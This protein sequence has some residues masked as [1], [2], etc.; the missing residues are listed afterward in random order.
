M[1]VNKYLAT[2]KGKFYL[3]AGTYGKYNKKNL[4]CHKL[5]VHGVDC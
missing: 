1:N 4:I 3:L 2:I 5:Y